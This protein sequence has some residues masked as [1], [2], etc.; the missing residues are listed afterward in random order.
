M[1]R[2]SLKSEGTERIAALEAE[3]RQLREALEWLAHRSSDAQARQHAAAS[4]DRIAQTS[5]RTPEID[6][7]WCI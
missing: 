5:Q 1:N 2:E 4:L 7:E 3:N 6:G